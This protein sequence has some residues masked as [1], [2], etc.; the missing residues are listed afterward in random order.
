MTTILLALTLGALPTLQADSHDIVIYGGTSAAVSAAIQATRM[1]RSVIIVSP[2][3]HLGGLTTSGLGWTDSGKKEAI[4]GIAR[5]FYRRIKKLYDRPEAWKQQQAAE[6]RLYRAD[7]DAMWTFEPHVAERVVE[8]MLAEA[9]V[10]VVRGALLDRESGVLKTGNTITAIRTL[11]GQTF[12]GK[13]FI[14]ATYEGDL[15]A[16]A[17][18]SYT[19]GREPNSQYQETLNGIQAIRAV[20]HQFEKPVDPYLVPGDPSSGLLPG[21]G[22]G[23]PGVD[24]EGDKRLQAYCFRMCLTDDP[25][26]RLPFAKPEGYD[27][28]RYELLGRYLRL[29]WDAVFRKFDPAPNRKTD[30]N[31]HGAFSTDNIGKNHDY[32]EASYTRR[33]EIIREHEQYQKGLMYYLANDPG[34]PEKVRLAMSRWG[35]ARDEFMDNGHWPHQ[36]YVREA[37]RLVADFVMTERHLRGQ[38]PTPE[39]V[40]MGS[41]NMDSHNVQ[42]YVDANGHARNEGDI[43]VNPGG[44]YPI[45][46]RAILPKAEECSNL[47]VPVC[48]SSSHIAYGS[49]RMEPVFFILGQSAATAA[50]IAIELNKPVQEIPYEKLKAR[51]LADGQV[52]ELPRAASRPRAKESE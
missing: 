24:G 48:L 37:R 36:I 51:L 38:E 47:L 1:G 23:P 25:E 45:S 52:L 21:I 41:Y 35:L 17:G 29:G 26:N 18:V 20:S 49:I 19:V 46:H 11:G 14:D 6:F 16:T 43:Q 42:R 5:A 10:P 28:Q 2:D 27:P 12:P 34:V 50:A 4:G 8:A 9:T 40:G 39:P 31:N 13:V 15:M 33:K 30:T 44:P 3:Q 7:D 22:P 32:P